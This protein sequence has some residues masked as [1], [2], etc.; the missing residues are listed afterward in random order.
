MFLLTHPPCTLCSRSS[1]CF[2]VRPFMCGMPFFFWDLSRASFIFN[3]NCL[4]I[5]WLHQI[6]IIIKATFLKQYIPTCITKYMSNRLLEKLSPR[7]IWWLPQCSSTKAAHRHVGQ[8][9]ISV[10]V[11]LK[12]INS[13]GNCFV[14][15][16]IKFIQILMEHPYISS[17]T[18][19]SR[20]NKL[21]SRL[22]RAQKTFILEEVPYP[23]E[24]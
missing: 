15:I 10:T 11:P 6:W 8:F 14:K 23:S 12:T 21:W 13:L 24:G 17:G 1:W 16:N 22:P 3:G 5:Y 9:W 19:D 2:P 18:K 20:K 7:S 4:L